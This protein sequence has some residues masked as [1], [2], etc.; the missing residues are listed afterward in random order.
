MSRGRIRVLISEHVVRENKM[1]FSTDKNV[2]YYG[3]ARYY[4]IPTHTVC[5][6]V[7]DGWELTN[8]FSAIITPRVC[9]NSSIFI[10]D[11]E[12]LSFKYST[13]ALLTPWS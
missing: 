7:V 2:Q 11:Y 13:S 6:V 4:G 8:D 10:Q 3:S 5:G 1:T 9:M 12:G